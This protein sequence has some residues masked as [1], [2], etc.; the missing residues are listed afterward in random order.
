MKQQLDIPEIYEQFMDGSCIFV[1]INDI[2]VFSE[3]ESSFDS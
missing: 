1:Y 2:L 3:Q